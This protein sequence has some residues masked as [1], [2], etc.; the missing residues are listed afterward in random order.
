MK[1]LSRNLKYVVPTGRVKVPAG[2]YVVPTGKDNVIVSTG[3]TKVIPAVLYN[4][5]R[6]ED[7]SRT[8]PTSGIRAWREPLKR[9]GRDPK[10]NIMILP[11]VSVEE[12]IAV[13]RETKA[14]T[15]LLQ[16]LPEDH[17]ADFHHLDDA[18]DIWLAVKARFGEGLHKGYGRF[19]KILSQLN[20]MQAKPDNED[21]NMIDLET[22]VGDGTKVAGDMHLLRDGPI[23]GLIGE[24]M[25]S[26]QVNLRDDSDVCSVVKQLTRPQ[27][28]VGAVKVSTEGNKLHWVRQ[29]S[30]GRLIEIQGGANNRVQMENSDDGVRDSCLLVLFNR[31][32]LIV[33]IV[34]L[35]EHKKRLKPMNFAP[36]SGATVGISSAIGT[37]QEPRGNSDYCRNSAKENHWWGVFRSHTLPQVKPIKRNKWGCP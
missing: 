23:E 24:S 11:P 25:T 35:L 13:Q 5:N 9:T 19:Q 36:N 15:I 7:L 33:R 17:M 8:G 32:G 37:S 31:L 30:M 22:G 18:R 28:E 2:R 1:D 10:G 3:R 29:E 4:L 16:S 20:Q 6:L 34:S 27:L 26:S 14:R 21:C 12:N